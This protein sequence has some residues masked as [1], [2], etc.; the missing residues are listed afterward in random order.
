M[1]GSSPV[2]I[3]ILNGSLDYEDPNHRKFIMLIIAKEL[4]TSPQLSSTATIT[5]TVTDANDN[6]P[7][8][9][10]KSYSAVVSEM[11]P[12][13]TL[14]TTIVAKDRDSGRF[15]ENGIVYE[16]LGEGAEKFV[17]NNRTGTVTVNDCNSLNLEGCLDFETMPEYSLLF[18]VCYL[19]RIRSENHEIFILGH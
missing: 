2:T 15:G 17:V 12:P 10:L 6:S 8:F 18:K 1:V 14:V 11:A 19:N 4:Y 5:V 9:D 7:S 13:G 16:L 3:K